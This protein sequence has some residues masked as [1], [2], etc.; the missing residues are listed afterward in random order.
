MTSEEMDLEEQERQITKATQILTK[1]FVKVNKELKD[2]VGE[3]HCP[4]AGAR[5]KLREIYRRE[6]PPEREAYLETLRAVLE[7]LEHGAARLTGPRIRT[8]GRAGSCCWTA[9]FRRSWC[10]T[11]TPGWIS[12]SACWPT[13][14]RR[15][16]RR[17]DLLAEGRLQIVCLGDGVHSEGRAARRWRAALEEFQEEYRVQ[18]A[19]TRRCGKASG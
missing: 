4:D 13:R 7:V 2:G 3:S 5:E 8:G 15:A 1:Q 14:R 18:T 16:G 11:C 12:S 10:L 6:E 19:W 9:G 17:M